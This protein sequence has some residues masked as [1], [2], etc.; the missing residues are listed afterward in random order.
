MKTRLLGVLFAVV[1]AL[2][3]I[4]AAAENA[5]YECTGANNEV[6]FTNVPSGSY[7]VKVLTYVAPVAAAPVASTAAADASQQTAVADTR[8]AAGDGDADKAIGASAE[9]TSS[10][11]GA[12]R[13]ARLAQ[14]RADAIQETRDAYMTDKPLSGANPAVNRR[15]LMITRADYQRAVG[16]TP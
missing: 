13:D 8:A 14:R 6:K 4:A 7:C 12:A 10:L 16:V 1:A 5:T 9:P 2:G 3:T 15:Y 11:P